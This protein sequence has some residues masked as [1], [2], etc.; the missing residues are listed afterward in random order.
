MPI[1]EDE[2][3]EYIIDGIPYRV[4]RDQARVSGFRTRTAL[5]EAFEPITLWDRKHTGASRGEEKTRYRQKGNGDEK[6]GPKKA[7][8]DE[9]RNCYNLFA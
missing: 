6:D 5:L 3:V 4:L 9:K 2:I 7:T 1:D 8:R